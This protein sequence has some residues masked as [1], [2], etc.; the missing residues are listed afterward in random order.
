MTANASLVRRIRR[1]LLTEWDPIG[2]ADVPNAQD[3]YDSY[4]PEI[5]RA[6]DA[7]A[8]AQSIAARLI[9]IETDRMGLAADRPRA[10]RVARLLTGEE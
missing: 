9:A 1:I 3:E 10:T 5:A 8:D 6:L 4:V 2:V 7:G